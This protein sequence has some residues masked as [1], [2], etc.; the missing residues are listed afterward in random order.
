MTTPLMTLNLPPTAPL[1]H[2]LL[3]LLLPLILSSCF[4]QNRKLHGCF[5]ID[6]GSDCRL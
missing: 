4:I 5:W 3:L 6:C 1:P 2:L